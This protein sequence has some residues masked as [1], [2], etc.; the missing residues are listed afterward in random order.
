MKGYAEKFQQYS[1]DEAFLVPGPDIKNFE[2]AALCAQR[3]NEE[4]KR[5]ERITCSVGIGP[6]KLSAR[7]EIT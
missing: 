5:Q 1:I 3:I 6:N 4:I 2:D 7:C